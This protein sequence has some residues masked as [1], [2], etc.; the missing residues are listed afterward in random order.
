MLSLRGKFIVFTAHPYCI[1]TAQLTK[2]CFDMNMPSTDKLVNL[3][4]RRIFYEAISH[5]DLSGGR[6]A[7][8]ET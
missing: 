2:K 7:L 6:T 4:A 1:L 5:F 3:G 8:A